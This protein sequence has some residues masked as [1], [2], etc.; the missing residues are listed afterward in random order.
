MRLIAILLLAALAAFAE[1]AA[2]K[3]KATFQG[4]NGPMEVLFN[5]Q[6]NEGKLTGSVT[7]PQGDLPV[8]DGK[9]DGPNLTFTLQ[10][11]EVKITNSATIAGDEM[12]IKGHMNDRDF[13]LTAKRL[14]D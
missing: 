1:G 2:G 12:K 7:T 13:E 10:H 9:V 11:D 4:Q 8:V 6:V 3:W 14:A 5:F